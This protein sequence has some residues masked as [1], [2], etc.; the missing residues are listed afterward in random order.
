MKRYLEA[1]QSINLIINIL[2]F[3]DYHLRISQ[4]AQIDLEDLRLHQFRKLRRKM[5]ISNSKENKSD[6]FK[7]FSSRTIIR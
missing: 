5:K 6:E 1:F 4:N 3:V 7:K 2:L